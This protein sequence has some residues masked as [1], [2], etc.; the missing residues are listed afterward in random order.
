MLYRIQKTIFAKYL[1]LTNKEA[2]SEIEIKELLDKIEDLYKNKI[3]IP[4]DI[5]FQKIE[6]I[7]NHLEEN[8]S[9]IKRKRIHK[10]V[11][12]DI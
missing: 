8:L 10:L 5:F 3:L 9:A 2:V 1:H 12:L 4:S 11:S 7:S 6:L